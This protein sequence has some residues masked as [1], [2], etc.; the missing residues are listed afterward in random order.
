VLSAPEPFVALPLPLLPE[1]PP[2]LLPAEPW[3]EV[4]DWSCPEV[5]CP[6]PEPIEPLPVELPVEPDDVPIEPLPVE[7]E[8]PVEP[9]L[10]EPL[11]GEL[12]W[13]E[14]PWLPDELLPE[15]LVSVWAI[16]NAPARSTS[17]RIWRICFIDSSFL[18]FMHIETRAPKPL[19]T[20]YRF[21]N[22]RSVSKD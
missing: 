1:A 18:S 9:V 8:L 20:S 5:L 11:L 3:L 6:E 10:D 12:C 22:A 21:R 13:A 19:R 16:T 4:P 14:L 17:A 15:P 2:M 7:V